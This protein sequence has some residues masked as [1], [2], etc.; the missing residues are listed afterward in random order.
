MLKIKIV[1]P[2][3]V[4]YENEVFQASIP[5][6]SG[7]ITVLPNH[8]PL[9]S[10]M[11][12]GELRI[13]DKTGE[14]HLA[15]SGGFVEVRGNNEIILLSD[16]AERVE[17]IDLQ[18]AEE[19]RQRAEEEIKAARNVEDVDFAKLQALIDRNMNRIRIAR[20]YRSFPGTKQ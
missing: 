9:V 1:T 11:K 16:H 13:K 19:A 5:T 7:E 14:V 17:E 4:V 6:M 18:R 10:V 2:E 20:K 8:I 3:K 15:V 12:A